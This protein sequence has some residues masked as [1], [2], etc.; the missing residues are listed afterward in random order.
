M[1]AERRFNNFMIVAEKERERKSDMEG[2]R[3]RKGRG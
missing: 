3:E 2:E 1:A